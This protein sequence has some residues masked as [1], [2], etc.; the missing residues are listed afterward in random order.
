M[1]V[2]IEIISKNEE[3]TQH[4][5]IQI[6]CSMRWS[7]YSPSSSTPNLDWSSIMVLFW[8]STG[9]VYGKMHFLTAPTTLTWLVYRLPTND[10]PRHDSNHSTMRSQPLV[11]DYWQFVF[12]FFSAVTVDD[13]AHKSRLQNDFFSSPVSTPTD[14]ATSYIALRE[15]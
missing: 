14:P 6:G 2:D 12:L 8:R 7:I 10:S 5:E 3:G 1:F 11:G 15:T 13:I 9:A 4:E